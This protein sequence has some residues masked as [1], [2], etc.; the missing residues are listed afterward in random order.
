MPEDDWYGPFGGGRWIWFIAL[1]MGMTLLVPA[2]MGH[3]FTRKSW[4]AN[5]SEPPTEWLGHPNWFMVVLGGAII[6]VA[7]LF[8]WVSRRH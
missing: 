2:Y 6:V 8:L 7:A 5:M 1:L 4:P 3:P